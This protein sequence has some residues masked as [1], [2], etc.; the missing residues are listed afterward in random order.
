MGGHKA[1]RIGGHYEEKRKSMTK[2]EMNMELIELLKA[3]QYH[4]IF[5]NFIHT[6][7]FCEFTAQYSALHHLTMRFSFK[8]QSSS[9]S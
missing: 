8:N 3:N 6:G 4:N 2:D 7:I 9:S 1:A 5:V